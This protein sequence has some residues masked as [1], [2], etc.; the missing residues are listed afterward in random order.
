MIHHVTRFAVLVPVRNTAAETVA[1]AMFEQIISMF[2]APKT[3][4]SDHSTIS[5]A[6]YTRIRK[7]SN[8]AVSAPRKFRTITS[9]YSTMYSMLAML[10]VVDQSNWAFLLLFVQLAHNTRFSATMRETPFF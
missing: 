6:K 5:V 3:F 8:D 10:S 9:T 7:D 4:H 1:H 2:G